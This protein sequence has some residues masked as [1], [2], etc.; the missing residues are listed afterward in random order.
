M[1]RKPKQ[2]EIV[3]VQRP[4]DVPSQPPMPIQPGQV[5]YDPNTGQYHAPASRR[6]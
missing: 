5:Y 3:R 2:N 4:E 6:R 1:T